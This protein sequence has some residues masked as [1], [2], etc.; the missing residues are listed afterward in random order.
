M[1]W[2]MKCAFEDTANALYAID[3]ATG[4]E[5]WHFASPTGDSM[6][7]PVVSDGVVYSGSSD[8]N[9]YAI[10]ATNG[11]EMGRF[12]TGDAIEASPTLADGILYFVSNDRNVY[13]IDIRDANELWRVAVDDGASK[14]PSIVDGT[15]YLG[16]EAGT[17][18]AIR[19]G[20]EPNS[21]A[22]AGPS[23]SIDAGTPDA[24][25]SS[26]SAIRRVVLDDAAAVDPGPPAWTGHG[27]ASS[28]AQTNG[29]PAVAP[30]GRTWVP[31]SQDDAFWIFAPDGTYLESLGHSGAR[32]GPARPGTR[33]TRTDSV[34]SRSN[35]TAPSMSPISAIIASRR[36]TRG[37]GS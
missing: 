17:V 9:M 26:G 15:A 3:A 33:G 31:A 1:A 20:V 12:A 19:E 10:D 25:P 37:G 24:S 2:C 14:G 8:G 5:R 36:S 29:P 13:A 11:A 30:D 28:R 27:P 23:S 32:G 21:S 35:P 7:V 6:W 22:S 16:T 18:Y 34:T 4:I